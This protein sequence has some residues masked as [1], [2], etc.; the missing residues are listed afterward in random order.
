MLAN[1]ESFFEMARA[2]AALL[3]KDFP[4]DGPH[5][6]RDR[7]TLAFERFLS[8]KPE[9]AELEKSLSFLNQARQSSAALSASPPTPP[10][11]NGQSPQEAAAWTALARGLMNTDEFITRE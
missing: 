3:W 10:S 11:L 1:D 2:T 6:D 7:V 9:P 5:A 4:A 8:R